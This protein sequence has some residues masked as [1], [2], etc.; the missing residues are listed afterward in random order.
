[1][2]HN[3]LLGL[4]AFSLP[5]ILFFNSQHICPLF[6]LFPAKVKQQLITDVYSNPHD[7]QL[8]HATE[9]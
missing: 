6:I 2:I 3:I 7:H 8:L 9:V 4:E 1:M 5:I